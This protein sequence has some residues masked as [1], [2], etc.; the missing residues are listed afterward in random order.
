MNLESAAK[1]IWE[2]SETIAD[3]KWGTCPAKDTDPGPGPAP[4][5]LCRT[6]PQ[7]APG[8][9]KS[10]GPPVQQGGGEAAP[11]LERQTSSSSSSSQKERERETERSLAS[12]NRGRSQTTPTHFLLSWS[13]LRWRR[14]AH[15]WG[16]QHC[17]SRTQTTRTSTGLVSWFQTETLPRKEQRVP[18]WGNLEMLHLTGG[19]C[20]KPFHEKEQKKRE[21]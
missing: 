15:C 5:P 14:K 10:A 8:R 13:A 12:C 4:G 21:K 11:A 18:G 6:S 17:T 2:N 1:I 20:I 9:G 19:F 16:Q 3:G 7:R